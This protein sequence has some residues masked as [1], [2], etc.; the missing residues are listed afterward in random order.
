MTEQEFNAGIENRSIIGEAPPEVEDAP[1]APPS[2]TSIEQF[3][4]LLMQ[5]QS[6]QRCLT[7]APTF[8]PQTFQDQIQFVFDGVMYSL[9]LYFSNQWNQFSIGGGATSINGRSHGSSTSIPSGADT[10]VDLTTND[11]ANGITWDAVNHRFVVVTAG[12]Y[13]ITGIATYTSSTAGALYQTEISINGNAITPGASAKSYFQAAASSLAIG[14]C[15]STI[16]N[17]SV[18]DYIELYTWQNSGGS[19]SLYSGS[20]LTYLAVAKV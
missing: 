19:R 11:F 13:L 2:T 14:P 18:G 17:L 5:L 12:Q 7:A 1:I 6:T 10:L 20:G 8:I 4:P 9:Y 15:V 3:I 16:A